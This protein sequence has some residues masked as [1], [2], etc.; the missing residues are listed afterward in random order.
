MFFVKNIFILVYV[1]DEILFLAVYFFERKFNDK[2]FSMIIL[3]IVRTEL[4][5]MKK[6]RCMQILCITNANNNICRRF[7]SVLL[8]SL[9]LHD[10]GI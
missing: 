3:K 10:Q 1:C 7:C 8:T 6:T 4:Y 5:S 2:N 9:F